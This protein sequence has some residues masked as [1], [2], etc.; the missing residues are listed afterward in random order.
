MGKLFSSVMLERL[1]GFK[2]DHCHDPIEQLGFHKGA[3]TNDHILTLKTTIDKY[4]KVQK[5]N[6][7]TCFVDLKKAF[8]TVTRD[9][10]LYKIVKLGIRGKFFNVIEDMYNNSLSKIK[11]NNLLSNKFNMERGT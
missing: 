11:I 7:L 3:Q 1:T 6:L 4:T 10:L 2:R 8:D 9:L 5:T